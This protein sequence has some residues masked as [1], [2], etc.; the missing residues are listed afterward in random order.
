M[1]AVRLVGVEQNRLLIAEV[2]MLD[3]TPLLDM[4]P[5]IPAFDCFEV[6]RTGWFHGKSV[7]GE[8]ADDRFEAQDLN[9]HKT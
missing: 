2:D 5:Y 6:T 9:P 1:S 3:G 4:K 8:V 7:Q